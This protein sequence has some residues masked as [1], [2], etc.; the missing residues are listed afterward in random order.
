MIVV[1]HRIRPGVNKP[2]GIVATAVIPAYAPVWNPDPSQDVVL[3]F[4]QLKKL[5][6]IEFEALLAFGFIQLPYTREFVAPGDSFSRMR[7]SSLT[8]DRKPNLSI[9]Y[10]SLVAARQIKKGE[11]MIAP[12]WFDQGLN[13]KRRLSR[14]GYTRA[15]NVNPAR[16]TLKGF[17]RYVYRQQA[18]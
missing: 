8:H 1:P 3:T 13:W 10:D 4:E 15:N 11:E 14:N 16:P 9:M 17:V 2:G 18:A 5:S 7:L 6:E 12:A